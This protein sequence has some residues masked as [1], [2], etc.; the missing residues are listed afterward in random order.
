M[1]VDQCLAQHL[2]TAADAQHCPALTDVL[3]NGPIETLLAQ[4]S[5]ICA[6]VLAAGQHNPV[7][8]LQTRQIS[9]AACPEQAHAGHIFEGLKLIQVADARI[10]NHGH[11]LGNEAVGTT[12]VIKNAIFFRQAVLPPH[13]QDRHR[14]HASQL[15][16]HLGRWGQQT[17]VASEFVEHEAFDAFLVFRLQQCPSAVQVGKRPTLVDVGHQQTLG[18]GIACHPQVDDVAVHEVD[19][20][21]R[22]CPL[23]HNHI[24]LGDQLIER[25]GN[26]RPNFLAALTPRCVAQGLADLAEQHHLAACVCLGLE[27]QRV[28]AHIGLDTGCQCLKILRTADFAQAV[29]AGHHS[30]VVAHV[31]RFEGRNLQA[32]ARV[33]AAQRR[34]QPAFASAAGCAQHHHTLGRHGEILFRAWARPPIDHPANEWQCACQTRL[35]RRGA[36]QHPHRPLDAP[37]GLLA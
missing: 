33:M 25:G 13:G 8:G 22:A 34:G 9:R 14:G 17:G 21:G 26:L 28:H 35:L 11:G 7:T 30:G 24:V 20:G 3:R 31:L 12:A 2:Q 6:G 23:D 19:L 36:L 18:I 32:H 37:R 29:C 1:G 16:Q 5:K 27:E 10:G 4:P 15:L